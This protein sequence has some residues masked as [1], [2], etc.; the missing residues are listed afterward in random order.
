LRACL[1][2]RSAE[3]RRLLLLP[4]ALFFGQDATNGGKFSIF[5]SPAPFTPHILLERDNEALMARSLYRGRGSRAGPSH[6]PQISVSFRIFVSVGGPQAAR[7]FNAGPDARARAGKVFLFI[8]GSVSTQLPAIDRVRNNATFV[9]HKRI[10]NG[11][12]EG[13]LESYV[14]ACSGCRTCT[15]PWSSLAATFK[16]SNV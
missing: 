15:F 8:R 4:G 5:S 16:I 11:R 6:N 1:R 7:H 10:L 14:C 9:R 2:P 12:N 3:R 13:T